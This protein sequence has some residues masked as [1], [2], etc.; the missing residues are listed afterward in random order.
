MDVIQVIF[1][2]L[3][4]GLLGVNLYFVF[5][6]KENFKE[7]NLFLI[8]SFV[9]GVTLMYILDDCEGTVLT[10]L[11]SSGSVLG[12]SLYT[13]KF[14]DSFKDKLPWFEKTLLALAVMEGLG[15]LG[16]FVN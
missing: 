13:L 1:G 4:V 5:Q 12:A 7:T 8:W 11:V 2:I 9:T 3:I 15:V 16:S 6:C 10:S 14:K